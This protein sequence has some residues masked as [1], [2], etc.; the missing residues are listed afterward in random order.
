MQIC[1]SVCLFSMCLHFS[2]ISLIPE[3]PNFMDA[4]LEFAALYVY[5]IGIATIT[6]GFLYDRSRKENLAEV[7]IKQD[8][9]P[10]GELMVILYF[11]VSMD[12]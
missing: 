9:M 8:I 5:G 11:F 6:C 2:C 1:M 4:A 10:G 12:L 7:V 3:I